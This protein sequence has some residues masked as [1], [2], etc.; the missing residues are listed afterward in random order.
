MFCSWTFQESNA[1]NRP[2][3]L[4]RT[5][6]LVHEDGK[7]N[8]YIQACVFASDQFFSL[9]V[10]HS[11][12]NTFMWQRLW[13]HLKHNPFIKELLPLCHKHAY[14]CDHFSWLSWTAR[15]GFCF[16]CF[17]FF[18]MYKYTYVLALIIW[19]RISGRSLFTNIF[20]TINFFDKLSLNMF[21]WREMF[22]IFPWCFVICCRKFHSNW[23][24]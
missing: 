9:A 8:V 15:C 10:V 18:Y 5:Y 19:N 13:P 23:I 17:Q 24:G 2:P 16:Q 22:C 6:I 3:H 12:P 21:L 11:L 4:Q 20:G 14:C 1:Q 7:R